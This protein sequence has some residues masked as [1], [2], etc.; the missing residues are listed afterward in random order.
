[1][2]QRT[3]CQSFAQQKRLP[4]AGVVAVAVAG[5]GEGVALAAVAAARMSRRALLLGIRTCMM[6]RM[7]VSN[8]AQLVGKVRHQGWVGAWLGALARSVKL[9]E[10]IV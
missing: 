6:R 8:V 7:E 1:M 5:A 4:V 3:T 2:L 10:L 9:T